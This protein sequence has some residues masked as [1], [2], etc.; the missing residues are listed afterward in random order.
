MRYFIGYI[1][2]V[3]IVSFI[4]CG[5]DKERSIRGRKRIRERTLLGLSFIGGCLGMEM[6]M[7]IFHHK[8]KKNKFRLGVPLLCLLWIILIWEVIKR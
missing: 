3:N 1:I 8:T 4:S 5:I 6:G 7:Y 2:V